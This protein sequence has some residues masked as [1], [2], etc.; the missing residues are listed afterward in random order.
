[1]KCKY[2]L[3]HSF[4]WLLTESVSVLHVCAFL[5]S[6]YDQRFILEDKGFV[7]HRCDGVVFGPGLEH[8]ALIPWNFVLLQL[9]HRPFPYGPTVS[10]TIK[11]AT[12]AY[13]YIID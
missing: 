1:M 9:L 5:N 7:Q 8:Q 13:K 10:K 3:N 2:N 4:I 11:N 6:L 12:W